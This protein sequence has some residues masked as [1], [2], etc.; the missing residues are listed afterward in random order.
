ME[1]QQQ[2]PKPSA[3]SGRTSVLHWMRMESGQIRTGEWYDSDIIDD[4]ITQ[5]FALDAGLYWITTNTI[6]EKSELEKQEDSNSLSTFLSV[7]PSA[8][9]VWTDYKT[10][11]NVSAKQNPEPDFETEVYALEKRHPKCADVIRRIY[12]WRVLYGIIGFLFSVVKW[13]ID[14]LTSSQN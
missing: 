14:L 11:D 6:V 8:F 9:F 3:V 1:Q 10:I 5:I 2:S 13:I 7:F 4:E 12:R